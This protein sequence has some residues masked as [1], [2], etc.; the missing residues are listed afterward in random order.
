M[1]L[2]INEPIGKNKKTRKR[3]NAL[4]EETK[5]MVQSLNDQFSRYQQDDPYS[6]PI[7]HNEF[8][9]EEEKQ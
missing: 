1:I 7:A 8:L 3:A 5:D 6:V 9:N 4:I 2:P